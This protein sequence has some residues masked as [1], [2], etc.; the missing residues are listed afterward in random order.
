MKSF[1]N[2][3]DCT[4]PPSLTLE[5]YKTLRHVIGGELERDIVSEDGAS[6]VQTR[7]NNH[8][9]LDIDVTVPGGDSFDVYVYLN[10]QRAIKLLQGQVIESS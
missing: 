4:R 10:Y 1:N 3:S 8:L 5:R 2:L 7:T 6:G 9:S